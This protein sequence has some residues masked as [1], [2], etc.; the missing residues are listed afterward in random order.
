MI[1]RDLAPRTEAKRSGSSQRTALLV[2]DKDLVR[3]ST[4]AMIADLGFS[5]AEASS[6]EE[7][8]RLLDQD[9]NPDLLVTDHLMPGPNG[10]DFVRRARENRPD[11]H[12]LLVSGYGESEGVAPDLPGLIKPFRQDELARCLAS[13]RSSSTTSRAARSQPYRPRE[14]GPALAGTGTRRNRAEEKFSRKGAGE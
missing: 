2:D 3:E 12:V 8:L 1:E 10:T 7:A 13:I 14:W 6:G 9:L 5:V 4:A 11:L